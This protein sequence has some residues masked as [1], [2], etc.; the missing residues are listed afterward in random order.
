MSCTSGG[1]DGLQDISL[2]TWLLDYCQEHCGEPTSCQP[3]N[4]GPTNCE[5]S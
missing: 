5:T 4:C 3:A 1:D 2:P